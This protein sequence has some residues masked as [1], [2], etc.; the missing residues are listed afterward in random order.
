MYVENA[1]TQVTPALRRAV[2]TDVVKTMYSS[3]FVLELFKPQE[4]YTSS[5]TRQV[6]ACV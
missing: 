4:A 1:A 5:S 3:K 2:L 6:R